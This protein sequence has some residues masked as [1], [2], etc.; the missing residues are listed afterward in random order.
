MNSVLQKYNSVRQKVLLTE[1]TGKTRMFYENGNSKPCDKYDLI[2]FYKESEKELF[3]E[4]QKGV[5]F[6]AFFRKDFV[7]ILILFILLQHFGCIR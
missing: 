5:E 1:N 3:P 7:L 6:N 4:Q 2:A